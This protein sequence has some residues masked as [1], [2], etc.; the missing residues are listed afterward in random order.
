MITLTLRQIDTTGS[1]D[2]VKDIFTCRT[3]RVQVP[4]IEALWSHVPFRVW[5]LETG[6]STIGYLDPLVRR[7]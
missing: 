6:D 2:A 7:L 3:Q 1:E 4:N 5:F